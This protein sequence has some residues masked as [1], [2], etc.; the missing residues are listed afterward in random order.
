[1]SSEM[2]VHMPPAESSYI[3]TVPTYSTYIQYL[4]T[5]VPLNALG[6]KRTAHSFVLHKVTEM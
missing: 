2:P 3:P 4:Q 1:M 5:T 6:G